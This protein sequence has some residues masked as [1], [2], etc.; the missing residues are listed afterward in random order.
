M[1]GPLPLSLCVITRDAAA[2]LA[3]C[4][5]SVPFAGEIV[6]VDSGSEDDTV[7]VARRCGARVIAQP[8]LGYGAEE[9]RGRAGP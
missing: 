8:W 1:S 2:Q 4:L 6:I 9:F 7:E 3:D 5:A